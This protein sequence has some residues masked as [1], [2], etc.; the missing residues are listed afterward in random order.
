MSFP[1]TFSSEFPLYQCMSAQELFDTPCGISSSL[2]QLSFSVLWAGCLLFWVNW[3][4]ICMCSAMWEESQRSNMKMKF[5]FQWI[6]S[7][8]LLWLPWKSFIS[9][10]KLQ[11]QMGFFLF[12]SPPHLAINY[13]FMSSFRWKVSCQVKKIKIKLSDC[14]FR[15]SLFP[16]VSKSSSPFHLSASPDLSHWLPICFFTALNVSPHLVVSALLQIFLSRLRMFLSFLETAPG[17]CSFLIN[18]A[19]K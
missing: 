3:W 6:F 15:V 7:K 16:R 17:F 2:S 8:V 9:F 19:R 12:I 13:T 1:C 14:H 5:F 11:S 4:F 18:R 10:S